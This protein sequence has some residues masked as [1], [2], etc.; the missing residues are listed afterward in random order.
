MKLYYGSLSPEFLIIITAA[1]FYTYIV[2]MPIPPD[3]YQQRKDYSELQSV[4]F[5][6]EAVAT[7][8]K[9]KAQFT[10]FV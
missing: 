4:Y 10:V 9:R 8:S 3:S 7:M 2:I 5:C 1:F 6:I